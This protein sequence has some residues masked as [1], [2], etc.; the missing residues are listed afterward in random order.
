M[1][2][3]ALYVIPP[4]VASVKDKPWEYW[5]MGTLNLLLLLFKVCVAWPRTLSGLTQRVVGRLH[6]VLTFFQLN[7]LY[8][9]LLVSSI[10]MTG[11][12]WDGTER[13]GRQLSW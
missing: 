12:E 1:A 9:W 3:L 13:S 4:N 8:L 7:S 11:R 5:L 6:E 10:F 2:R